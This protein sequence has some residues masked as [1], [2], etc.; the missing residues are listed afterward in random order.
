VGPNCS[1]RFVVGDRCMALL[2]GG[3]YAEYAVAYECVTMHVPASLNMQVL[4]SIPEQWMTAYQLLFIVGHVQSGETVLL[5]AA[6]SGVGQAAIQLAVKAGAKCFATCR[7]ELKVQCCLDLGAT[8]ALNLDDTTLFNHAIRERNGGLG[9][10]LILD[11]VGGGPY[12]LENIDALSQDGRWVLYGTMGGRGVDDPNFIGKILAKRATITGTTL[13][14][15]DKEYKQVLA[16]AI[17]SEVL[18]EV[19][20]GGFKV[21]IDSVFPMTTE[22]VREAH[23]VMSSNKNIG[24]IV[25][26]VS[27]ESPIVL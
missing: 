2:Q 22:G 27:E 4:A 19:V 16:N 26:V 24:K 25:L 14:S 5:H 23:R 12:A 7:S 13:R 10:N 9:V 18:P 11:P 6:A 17:E 20:S 15:R 3:G 1:G 8:T 21:L